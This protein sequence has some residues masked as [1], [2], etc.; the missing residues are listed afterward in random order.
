LEARVPAKIPPPGFLHQHF[1]DSIMG[2]LSS[3]IYRVAQIGVV[4]ISRD[5]DIVPVLRDSIQRSLVLSERKSFSLVLQLISSGD[6][7]DLTGAGIDD[8][9]AMLRLLNMVK[10]KEGK[11]KSSESVLLG[12][13]GIARRTGCFR[14]AEKSLTGQSSPSFLLETAKVYLNLGQSKKSESII[15]NL[16]LGNDLALSEPRVYSDACM[17]AYKMS[18]MNLISRNDLSRKSCLPRSLWTSEYYLEQA[19]S[20]N[21]VAHFKLAEMFFEHGK[22]LIGFVS[23]KTDAETRNVWRL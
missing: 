11:G 22:E 4:A 3:A 12:L 19:S 8:S 15:S 20:G 10:T 13:A 17:F 1:L 6:G 7:I 21:A 23:V 18:I 2:G 5:L 16:L 14:L 9:R